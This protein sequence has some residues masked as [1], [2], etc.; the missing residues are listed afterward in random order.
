MIPITEVQ[1]YYVWHYGAKMPLSCMRMKHIPTE[2]VVSASEKDFKDHG[3]SV[4]RVK[5]LLRKRL[6]EKVNP[7]VAKLE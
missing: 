1:V 4:H 3:N 6:T 7:T 5:Q 2:I